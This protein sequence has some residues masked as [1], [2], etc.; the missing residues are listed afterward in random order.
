MA[1]GPLF[2]SFESHSLSLS[3]S[4]AHSVF[5]Y[6][7]SWPSWTIIAYSREI[8]CLHTLAML[9]VS[10]SWHSQAAFIS[11]LWPQPGQP[12][13]L[14]PL[15]LLL[16]CQTGC[17]EDGAIIVSPPLQPL[18]EEVHFQPIWSWQRCSSI[19]L[20]LCK[21]RMCLY[22]DWNLFKTHSKGPSQSKK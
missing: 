4:P 12:L 14:L 19:P 22:N 10:G 18:E 21:N 16:L 20:A 11:Q 13:Q 9:L 6:F 7:W 3:L 5:D 8:P 17:L 15:L 1:S 2:P